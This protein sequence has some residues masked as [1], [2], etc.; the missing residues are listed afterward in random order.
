MLKT[1]K[2]LLKE[3]DL[4]SPK[5]EDEIE[6]FRLRFLGKKGRIKELFDSFKNVSNENKKDVGRAINTL[7]KRVQEK[8]DSLKHE[9]E[10]S[11]K[12]VGVDFTR[13]VI[14]SSLGSRHPISIIKNQI[15]NVFSRIGFTISKGP[16]IEDD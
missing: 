2:Y 7:K 13:P 11:S 9:G 16:E 4:F 3:V 8:I 1:V 6:A 15:L 14:L 12:E 5:S 10:S